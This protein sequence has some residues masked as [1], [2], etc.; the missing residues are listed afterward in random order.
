MSSVVVPQRYSLACCI[1]TRL[2]RNDVTFSLA[3]Q[4]FCVHGGLFS[5][6]GVTLDDIRAVDRN[7][8]PPDDGLMCEML[9]S[10]PGPLPGRQPS[11]RGVA[12]TFGMSHVLQ[13]AQAL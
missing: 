11:K 5:K 6:D 10:D 13:A 3:M 8:E 9:W 2:S 4:V 1:P 12:I 7:R